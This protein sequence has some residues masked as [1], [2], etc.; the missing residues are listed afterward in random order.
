MSDGIQEIRKSILSS[1]PTYAELFAMSRTLLDELEQVTEQR[2]VQYPGGLPALLR[3]RE[4]ACDELDKLQSTVLSELNRI[5]PCCGHPARCHREGTTATGKDGLP[6]LCDVC[7]AKAVLTELKQDDLLVTQ[8]NQELIE[9]LQA[10][11]DSLQAELQRLRAE[12]A[13]LPVGVSVLLT[14]GNRV[15]LGR[16][17]NCKAAGLMSTPGGRIERDETITDCARRE[18]QEETGAVL[19]EISL[20]AFR[21]YFR[22]GMHYFMVYVHARSCSGMITTR[23]PEKCE[24]WQFVRFDEIGDDCTEPKDI[25]ALVTATAVCNVPGHKRADWV[26]T[27]EQIRK[28]EE[29]RKVKPDTSKVAGLPMV[30]Y[31]FLSDAQSDLDDLLADHQELQKHIAELEAALVPFA[32]YARVNDNSPS[33]DSLPDGYT[34]AGG[35]VGPVFIR[36]GDCRK[37]RAV[38]EEKL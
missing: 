1:S 7:D 5:G 15:L 3:E 25:L 17:K 37:A 20:V 19:G 2:D 38:L 30:S 36:L 9:R 23:E 35:T 34:V 32:L 13:T 21:E 10:D 22:F 31:D 33:S 4:Q 24:C 8:H 26:L 12:G 27:D 18:F 28:I 6:H 16:R 29:R 14:E 11:C